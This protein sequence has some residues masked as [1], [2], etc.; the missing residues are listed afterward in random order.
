MAFES[1]SKKKSFN[2]KNDSPLIRFRIPIQGFP[3]VSTVS[4]KAFLF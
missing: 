4:I 3:I 1:Q 2:R